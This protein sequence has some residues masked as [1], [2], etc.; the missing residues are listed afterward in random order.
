MFL[1]LPTLAT[2]SGTV[3]DLTTHNLKINSSNP[4]AGEKMGRIIEE[5]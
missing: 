2:D 5:L 1:K 3:V 4:T